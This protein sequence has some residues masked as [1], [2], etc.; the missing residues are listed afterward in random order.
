MAVLDDEGGPVPAA[1]RTSFKAAWARSG[2]K[3]LFMGMLGFSSGLPYLLSFATLSLRLAQAGVDIVLIGFLAWVTLLNNLKFL[4]AP[5]LDR[6]APPGLGGRLGR[7]GGWVAVC[8]L[9]IAAA[10]AGQAFADPAEG[11]MPVALLA[12][13][14]VFWSAS[15]DVAVDAWRIEMAE[16]AAEMGW[17]AAAHL[18]GY[19][20]AM[21]VAGGGVLF[22]AGTAGWTAA[23]LAASGVMALLCLA[24]LLWPRA[25]TPQRGG[26][27]AGGLAAAVLIVALVSAAILALGLA[28][29]GLAA[30]LGLETG[31]REMA[32]RVAAVAL[33][34]FLA[35]ALAIP[36]IRRAGPASRWG[37]AHATAGLVEFLH[38]F[39]WWALPLLAFA[40]LFRLGDLVMAAIGKTLYAHVGYAPQTVG[41]V[42]GTV[43]LGAMVLGVAAGGLAAGKLGP[44]R[45]L[46]LGGAVAALGNL[47]F[48][49]L[50]LSPAEA[51]R[52]A[53][54]VAL[55]NF[56]G[57]LAAT[58]FIVFLSGLTSRAHAGAQYALLSSF[59][60]LVPQ[61]VAGS[62][63]LLQARFGYAGFFAG[64]AALALPA[65]ALVPLVAR[66]AARR[67]P[68]PSRP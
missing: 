21:V 14:T 41:A 18:W 66:I 31:R 48:A 44:A 30:L 43:G 45:S 67:L 40:A 22:L 16:G 58:V 6:T 12:L 54:A 39:G 52:L 4:W 61:L 38:R 19:R 56:G 27:L 10:L 25:G 2:P 29:P 1:P 37:R 51:W 13:L 8:Q 33:L 17:L 50:S 63:G 62:S 68:S 5:V 55:D 26:G 35:A 15:Q 24:V 60:F 11:L 3:L 53:A 42:E 20:A 65:L 59:A 7:R 46:L 9:G 57:G 34:P 23:Y 47:A 32:V 49:W 28:A 64:T 36:W